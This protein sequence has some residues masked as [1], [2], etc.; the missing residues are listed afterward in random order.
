[1]QGTCAGDP[2]RE[3]AWSHYAPAWHSSKQLWRIPFHY[4]GI[5]EHIQVEWLNW[6]DTCGKKM[7]RCLKTKGS[8]IFDGNDRW[9]TWLFSGNVET[10][11]NEEHDSERCCF[12]NVLADWRCS[13]HQPTISWLSFYDPKS[14]SL[15]NHFLCNST[16]VEYK[17]IPNNN[18]QR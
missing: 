1:M 2:P 8:A 12:G 11:S 4:T 16:M 3:Q 6:E 18:F 9:S 15:A 5:A 10:M 17:R 14:G 7:W 13:I